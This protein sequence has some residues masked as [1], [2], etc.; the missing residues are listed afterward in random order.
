MAITLADDDGAHWLDALTTADLD[1]H[2]VVSQEGN[3]PRQTLEDL[4]EDLG[5][6]LSGVGACLALLQSGHCLLCGGAPMAM[7]SFSPRREVYRACFDGDCADD[8]SALSTASA[9]VW[10]TLLASELGELPR[11]DD[12][13][14]IARLSAGGVEAANGHVRALAANYSRQ[15][16]VSPGA[17]APQLDAYEALVGRAFWRCASHCLR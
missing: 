15:T 13:W 5:V 7:L 9:G 11:S 8:L 12:H 16:S 14:L 4:A 6:D 10:L 17:G 2:G 3:N 1:L